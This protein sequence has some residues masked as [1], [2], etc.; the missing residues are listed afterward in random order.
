M[1]K[2]LIKIKIEQEVQKWIEI[3]KIR[4]REIKISSSALDFIVEVINNIEKDPSRNW[5]EQKFDFDYYQM[6]AIS[7][8]PN[9]LN[10]VM[11]GRDLRRLRYGEIEISTWDIWLSLSDIIRNW[12]FIPRDV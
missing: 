3:N 4:E 1:E 10:D 7:I 8:V 2:T 5:K 6:Q 9:A 12:C 11:R